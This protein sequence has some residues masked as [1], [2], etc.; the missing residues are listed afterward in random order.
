MRTAPARGYTIVELLVAAMVCM[1]LAAVLLT[2][3]VTVFRSMSILTAKSTVNSQLCS[4]L[5]AFERDAQQA[6][7]FP[8][9]ACTRTAT[10]TE[11]ILEL[12]DSSCVVW[13][14]DA[15]ACTAADP[16]QLSRLIV[17]PAGNILATRTAVTLH[18]TNGVTVLTFTRS[19]RLVEMRLGILSVAWGYRSEGKIATAYALRST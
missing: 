14:C 4:T 19:A 10:A 16:G 5:E 9:S 8:A 18:S 12:P 6:R 17:S 2:V 3:F 15:G 11:I 7:S 1:V 13:Q